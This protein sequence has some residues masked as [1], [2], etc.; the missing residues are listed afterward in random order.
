MMELYVHG[1]L[2][3]WLVPDIWKCASIIIIRV[4]YRKTKGREVL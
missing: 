1:L 2:K 4:L 3:L